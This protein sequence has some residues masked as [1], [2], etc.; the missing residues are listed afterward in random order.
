MV[1][2]PPLL[3]PAIVTGDLA[4]ARVLKSIMESHDHLQPVE[5]EAQIAAAQA[6]FRDKGC[7]CLF[8]DIFSLDT[9]QAIEFVRQV[10]DKF[11][12]VPICLYSKLAQL[13]LMPD[14]DEQWRSRFEHY[15]KLPSDQAV[16]DLI[17]NA[18][19]MLR[20]MAYY[21]Q[22]DVALD[23]VSGLA[24]RVH[25]EPG[26]LVIEH[27]QK[28]ELKEM[29]ATIEHVL[30]SREDIQRSNLISIVP[31]I[32]LDQIER[33]VNDT[34]R[35]A[36]KSIQM[37]RLVNVL[38]L[39]GGSLLVAASFI[40]AATTARWE[41]IAFGGFGIAGI[42]AAL[43]TSPLKAISVSA[44]R[45]IQV[46]IVYFHFLSQ[47]RLLSQDTKKTSVLDR[48]KRLEEAMAQTVLALS[49]NRR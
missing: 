15:F 21:L 24:K 4:R 12:L 28:T 47:L 19:Y 39:L 13:S 41:A 6:L 8:I 40:I 9:Q 22:N 14:V 20:A 49:E 10:R 16:D 36:N 48:S 34:L 25:E 17:D 38:V 2:G 7:N 31:G 32:S 18:Q 29:L 23:K 43:I 5:V 45:I 44:N 3:K 1:Q 27:E 26:S 46:Q 35:D 11:P 42:I 30:K 33:L 37:A